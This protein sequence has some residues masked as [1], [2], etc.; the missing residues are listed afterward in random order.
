MY[1]SAACLDI[2]GGL[3]VAGCDTCGMPTVSA[4]EQAGCMVDQ[5]FTHYCITRLCAYH[6]RSIYPEFAPHSPQASALRAQPNGISR[7]PD[8]EN[9]YRMQMGMPNEI[10]P[11][12]I[13]PN[14]TSSPADIEHGM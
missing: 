14:I 11:P 4:R 6:R 5:D 7:S 1:H 3:I 2:S 12:V 8:G 9:E 13:R 10:A